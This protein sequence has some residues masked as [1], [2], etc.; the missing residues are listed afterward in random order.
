MEILKIGRTLLTQ[1]VD[2]TS[3][4]HRICADIKHIYLCINKDIKLLLN[5]WSAEFHYL[6][7]KKVIITLIRTVKIYT[8][9]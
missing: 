8:Y 1:L 6:F 2:E 9:R 5:N 3:S 4:S 7:N